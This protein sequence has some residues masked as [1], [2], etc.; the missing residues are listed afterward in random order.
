MKNK[1]K[2][3]NQASNLKWMWNDEYMELEAHNT[4]IWKRRTRSFIPKLL[5]I[6][7]TTIPKHYVSANHEHT[8]TK[9]NNKAKHN[10]LS[11]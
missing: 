3:K 7:K 10:S 9:M 6:N 5:S 2:H 4:I 8:T 11:I 1:A